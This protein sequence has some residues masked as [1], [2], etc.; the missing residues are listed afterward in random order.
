MLKHNHSILT[1]VVFAVF[2][3]SCVP[4]KGS[5]EYLSP[6][7]VSAEAVVDGT[8]V[9]MDCSLSAPRAETVGFVYWIVGEEK[10]TVTCELSGTSF[11]AILSSLTP[12]KTYQWYAFARAG[13]AEVH[14]PTGSF[15]VLEAVSPDPEPVEGPEGI[16][17]PDPYFRRYLLENFDS[18]GDGALSEEEAMIIR[19]IDVVT[20]KISSL[21]GIEHFKNLDSL[22]CRGAD[23]YE[24][25]DVGHPGMLDTLDV[26]A[27]RKLRYLACDKNMLRSLDMS[28]NP[29]LDEVLC[30]Y[31]LL[32]EIDLSAVPRLKLLRMWSNDVSTLDLSKTPLLETLECGGNSITGID[33]SRCPQ[34]GVLNVGDMRIKELDLSGNTALGW[35]G[36][37]GTDITEIDLS[38]NPNLGC[39]DCMDS[40]LRE[41][42]LSYCSKLQELKCWACQL[43][44][45]NVSMLPRLEILECSPMNGASG[46][47]LLKTLYV[48]EDQEIPGVTVDRS[49]KN[50]PEE[51][52]IVTI[53]AGTVIIPDLAFK[54]WLLERFDV[55]RDGEISMSEAEEIN[56]IDLCSNELNITSLKGIEFMP[57][58]EILRCRGDWVGT[59]VIAREHY[60]IS[61]HYNWDE[62]VGPIGTLKDIDVRHNP[63][64][65]I[66]DLSSNSA[67]GET[68][69]GTID[70]SNNPELEELIL[71]M[72]YIHYPD[73]S[74]CPELRVINFSHGL[75]EMPDFSHL[76]KLTSLEVEHHQRGRMQPVDVSGSP[77]LE[78]LNLNACASSLSDLKYNPK[79]RVLK[80]SWCGDVRPDLSAL[81]LLEEYEQISSGLHTLDFPLLKNLKV[82]SVSD[83]PLGF[84]DLS[85]MRGLKRLI[86]NSCELKSLDITGMKDLYY[87][88]CSWNSISTI[89]FSASPSLK[90]IYVAGNPLASI[91]VTGNSNLVKLYCAHTGIERLDV[92]RNRNLWD[93]R[94]DNNGLD[95]LDVS[96][97]PYLWGL[98]CGNN[99]LSALDISNN[100]DLQELDCSSNRLDALDLS[101]CPLLRWLICGN[102]LIRSLDVSGNP[103]FTGPNGDDITGLYCAPMN[104][105]SGGNV[106][107]SVFVGPGQ[108]IPGVTENRST[109]HI[110]SGTKIVVK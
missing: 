11:R 65:K 4:D 18:D 81:P 26:S 12:G 74:P 40:P 42:D 75:G 9:G 109:D 76:P 82:L 80:V 100:H 6:E 22:L 93:L 86:C 87:L 72:C 29:F 41:L 68:G 2:F 7:I 27:N 56:E 108:S 17:V 37:Y 15:T 73:I 101:G 70:L 20:D 5:E 51:T 92:T 106:L 69:S 31:N 21:R 58:L 59:T 19:K 53:K 28:D 38:H 14:S 91:D 13:D 97:N 94:C 46:K 32:E 48:S 49:S 78:E 102:N 36:I 60:Y 79:L 96:A 103:H 23:A 90:E 33:V 67:I 83:N 1:G 105:P 77:L 24:Y 61:K 8:T 39:L 55:D 25:D 30:S 43:E 84:L 10:E 63:K 99:S 3:S 88:E 34:L 50:V 107:E 16:D 54:N 52:E 110:P 104:G 89:D 35:L 71:P 47:N 66:L 64:L 45:L 98:Y 57:N 62:C 44:E 85:Q 95:S